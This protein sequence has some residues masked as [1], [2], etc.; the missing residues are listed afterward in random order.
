[1]QLLPKTVKGI[2]LN[3]NKRLLWVETQFMFPQEN[4]DGCSFVLNKMD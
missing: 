3:V 1:M 4:P 2:I